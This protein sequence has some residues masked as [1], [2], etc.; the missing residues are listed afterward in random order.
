MNARLR[1]QRITTDPAPAL[2][3]GWPF[4]RLPEYP[5]F[6]RL[7]LGRRVWVLKPDARSGRWLCWLYDNPQRKGIPLGSLDLCH[8]DAG[9]LAKRLKAWGKGAG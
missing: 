1:A 9:K 3:L 2:T 7:L 5:A 8:T 4:E 6:Y